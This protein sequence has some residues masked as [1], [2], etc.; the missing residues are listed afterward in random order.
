M[1]WTS[2]FF[3]FNMIEFT[4]LQVAELKRFTKDEFDKSQIVDAA[5]ELR[6]TAEINNL[7]AVN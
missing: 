5:R 1:S 7:L 4:E 2:P 6:Y 3:E